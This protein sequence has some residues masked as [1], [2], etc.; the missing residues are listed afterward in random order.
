MK[1]I[2]FILAAVTLLGGCAVHTSSHERAYVSRGHVVE[3]RRGHP[4][5][6]VVRPHRRPDY[7][8]DQRSV[9][10]PAVRSDHRRD[11]RSDHRRDARTH[12]RAGR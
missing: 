1:K 11:A 4:P 6:K 12:H 2:L 5:V 10:R 9:K 3:Q 7:R 8:P